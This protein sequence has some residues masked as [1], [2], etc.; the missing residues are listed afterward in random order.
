MDRMVAYCG[1][2]CTEC[3]AY[4]ATQAN[5]Q[6]ALEQMAQKAREEYGMPD[7]TAEGVRCDGCLPAEG[8]KC[9]YCAHCQV[10]ACAIER[11]L[12]NCA[13]C[14][15]YVCEKLEAFFGMAPGARMVLDEIRAGL[16]V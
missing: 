11:G 2:V 10:R 13:H 6:A 8:H 14:D 3:E 16:P 4:L 9:G 12:A 15:D 5:D 7:A 1:L